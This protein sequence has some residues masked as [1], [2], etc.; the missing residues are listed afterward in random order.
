MICIYTYNVYVRNAI[1]Y[2]PDPNDP[3][4]G[5]TFEPKIVNDYAM[6]LSI[7]IIYSTL[8]DGT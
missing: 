2:I 3:E 7:G 1:G 5:G 6:Y 8:Y 4:S